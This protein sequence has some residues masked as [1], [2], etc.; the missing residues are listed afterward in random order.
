MSQTSEGNT[1][2]DST[3]RIVFAGILIYT[4]VT[5]FLFAHEKPFHHDESL[6]AYYSLKIARGEPHVYDGML[7]G[8]ILYYIVGAFMFLFGSSNVV[9][10]V[11]PSLFGVILVCLPLLVRKHIGNAATLAICALL[12][13][14]PTI[15]YFGRFLREDVFTSVWVLGTVFGAFLYYTTRKPWTAYF[16][17]AMLAFHFTNKENS[18][19]HTFVWALAIIAIYFFTRRDNQQQYEAMPAPTVSTFTLALN[20]FCVFGTIF[21]LFYSSFFRH[22]EGSWKGVWD[23][24]YGKSLAY[25]WDQN[26]KRRIDGPFDYHLPILANY[27]FLLVPFVLSAWYH[28]V[29]KA[30]ELGARLFQNKG[31]H[32]VIGF[33]VALV[34]VTLFAPRVAFVSEV[35]HFTE[36]CPLIWTSDPNHTLHKIA[37]LLHI[38]HSRHLLQIMCY[39]W[40]GGVAFFALLR[41]SKKTDAF[42]WF[43]LTAAFGVYSYVGEKVPWLT[44]YIVLPLILIAGLE[45]ARLYSH[46][47]QRVKTLAT[48]WLVAAVPFTIFKALRVSFPD[49]ANPIERLVFTQTTPATAATMQ[50]LYD[51]APFAVNNNIRVTMFGEATWPIAWYI[52]RFNGYNFIKPAPEQAKDFDAIFVDSTTDLKQLEGAYPDFTVYQMPLRHWWVPQPNPTFSEMMAYFFIRQPYGGPTPGAQGFGDTTVFYLE[53]SDANSPFQTLAP[54]SLARPLSSTQP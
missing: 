48:V 26:Q 13:I 41:S 10:H 18:Y 19:L 2:S 4:L 47:N 43:W 23:G 27:E 15:T 8:P 44:T 34:L 33:S 46:T 49:A 30:K 31:F 1:K 29:A 50:R 45:I 22:P 51:A 35:C 37:K 16:A 52:Q 12:A 28:T 3:F 9:A 14:S 53:R 11:P 54:A 38:G 20:C 32:L 24:I 17:S 25:W 42:L 21:I 36:L 40:L 5:R 39:V 6:H 7:H